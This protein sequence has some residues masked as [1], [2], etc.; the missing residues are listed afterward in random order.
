MSDR[1]LVTG[2]SRG[3]GRAIA[4]QLAADGWS[5]V[6]NYR[7]SEEAARETE[8][9]ITSEG[10][11]A[12]RLRFDVSDREACFDVLRS[13]IDE[14]GS[15]YGLVANAGI[16]R[17]TSFALME[18]EDWDEVVNVNL[19]GFF[20]VLKP[21]IMPMLQ[22]RNGG[23]IVAISSLSGQMGNPGQVNYSASKAG[24]IGAV[25]SLAREFGP[26][27]ITANCVAPGLIDTE[28]VD[29]LPLDE[30]IENIPLERIGQ[31]EE[32]ASVVS[33]LC[34]EDASYVTGEVISVSG[35]MA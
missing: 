32:V 28:M 13:D 8:E 2:A 31:P 9:L 10:G 34:S 19:N 12:E 29:D 22:E 3:I 20:N 26:R 21:L 33:F 6:L 5:V 24:V 7:S 18:P 30:F 1:I 11:T 25:R 35:G 15:Y 17:D 23:R 14:N 4:I 16:R 27:N